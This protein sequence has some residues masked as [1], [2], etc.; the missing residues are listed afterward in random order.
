MKIFIC[1]R[2]HSQLKQIADEL[3]RT[4]LGKNTP[5]VILGSRQNLCLN[6]AVSKLSSADRINDK[7]LELQQ[8]KSAKKASASV[9]AEAS[10]LAAAEGGAAASQEGG[11]GGSGGGALRGDSAKKG[12]IVNLFAKTAAAN[13]AKKRVAASSASSG[14]GGCE[15]REDAEAQRELR[16][17]SLAQVMSI[18]DLMA[19]GREKHTCPYYASRDA[20]A[21]AQVVALPYPPV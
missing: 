18:E 9:A 6:P 12:S 20:L 13:A 5:F 16:E 19:R 3:K 1:S 8:G 11:G 10:A 14:G 21:S 2:T 15:Y 4:A 17:L 7:C